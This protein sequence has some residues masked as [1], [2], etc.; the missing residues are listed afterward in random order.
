MQMQR[1][2][3]TVEKL[4]NHISGKT[5]LKCQR[6]LPINNVKESNHSYGYNGGWFIYTPDRYIYWFWGGDIVISTNWDWHFGFY[7]SV[8]ATNDEIIYTAQTYLPVFAAGNEN[9]PG[10][11]GPD[12]QPFGHYEYSNGVVIVSSAI[13]PLNDAQGGFNTLTA[14]G[15]SKNNL[16]IGAVGANT[17]GYTG[18]NSVSIAAFSSMGA[19]T[20]GRI[21]PDVVADER[22][23][24]QHGI[25]GRD[26]RSAE[27]VLSNRPSAMRNMRLIKQQANRRCRFW[28]ALAVALALPLIS[29]AQGIIYD[30]LPPSPSLGLVQDPVTG[31]WVDPFAPYDAQGLRLWGSAENPAS[32]SLVLN[33]QVAFTFNS[34]TDFDIDPAGSNMVIGVYLDSS[35]AV[36]AAPLPSD[37][38]IGPDPG[39]YAWLGH[40]PVYGPLVLANATGS[41]IIGDPILFSGPFAGVPSA[42]IGL[43]F[44]EDNQPYYGW[45]RVGAPASINGGWIYDYAY[46]TVPNTPI[47]AGAVPEPSILALLATGTATLFF[48]RKG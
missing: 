32:Y 7:N 1:V 46:E 34:G 43:E 18:T 8:S 22:N 42:Y 27:S 23:Q 44:Y 3:Q 35:S 29:K 48:R 36:G 24:D 47:E 28:L 37:A 16:V 38:P 26:E 17:N 33:G 11:H 40:D 6:R 21:K 30:Q 4:W 15:V 31:Q 39:A 10:Q 19:T 9:G 5:W 13:R 25:H 12:T 41:G 20:D 45:V 14:Y 2:S